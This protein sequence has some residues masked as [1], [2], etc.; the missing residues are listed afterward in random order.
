M[1]INAQHYLREPTAFQLPGPPVIHGEMLL[2]I[3][4]LL[5]QFCAERG[6]YP[7]DGQRHWLFAAWLLVTVLNKL[8]AAA[9]DDIGFLVIFLFARFHHV[10][11]FDAVA[12]VHAD[13]G[14]W[15]FFGVAVA[16][17][18]IHF[19]ERRHAFVVL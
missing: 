9:S 7:S 13:V 3:E 4:K 18:K 19:R 2:D 17:Q 10:T 16:P 15:T 1:L 11:L 12:D 5:N 6:R 14:R 8:F